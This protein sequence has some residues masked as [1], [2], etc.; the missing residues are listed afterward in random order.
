MATALE[1]IKFIVGANIDNLIS[2]FEDPIAQI[3]NAIVDAKIGYSKVK[4]NG[5]TALAEEARA[6]KAYE[7]DLA[8]ATAMHSVAVKAAQAGNE[9]DAKVALES[10]QK[11]A[12]SAETKKQI[13]DATHIAAEKLRDSLREYQTAIKEMEGKKAEIVAKQS[14][15]NA[16]KEVNKLTDVPHPGA[17]SAFQ[18]LQAKADAEYEQALAESQINKDIQEGNNDESDLMKKYNGFNDTQS[19]NAAYDDLLKEIGKK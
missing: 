17:D 13:Y 5:A 16:L 1:R 3:N 18:R 11:Y 2:K 8:K 6:K 10:E 7:D 15:A 14:A 9:A 4:A 12:K 19:V